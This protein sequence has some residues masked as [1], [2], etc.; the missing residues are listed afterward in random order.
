MLITD[1]ALLKA[2]N[3]IGSSV[4]LILDDNAN[5]E[6]G[7]Y[8]LVGEV[9]KAKSEIAQINT[10]VTLGTTI[11]VDTLTYAHPIGT[12]VYKIPYNQVKFYYS[13]T[14][15]GTK[16]LLS[17]G[18]V[19]IDA[20][21]EYTT[22]TDTVNSSGYLFFTLY[23][24][25]TTLETGYSAG[26]NYGSIQYGSRIKIRE[27]VTSKHNWSKELDDTT[28]NTLCDFAESE[29]FSIRRWRFREKTVTFDTVVNQQSYAK[30]SVGLSDMGQMIFCTYTNSGGLH[31][32]VVPVTI[33]EYEYINRNQIVSGNPRHIWEW[34]DSIYLTP[35]PSEI[36]TVSV[37]YYR[38][39][40]GFSDETSE[41]E[42]KLPQAI[43]YRILQDLW[44]M[45][46]INK[47]QYFERRYLQTISAM[48]LD[49]IKQ[50][51]KMQTLSDNRID[52][53]DTNNQIDNPH[54]T[55]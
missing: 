2:P 24:S 19:N 7:D 6:N 44:A 16:T 10:A 53:L 47:S 29:I 42:V 37:R 45:V 41:S 38:N 26:F 36:A 35:I 48:K 12:M 8:I 39:S 43:S 55:L 20:Q 21:N 15:T 11:V 46:D 33:K 13:A 32:P 31:Q 14:L 17:G 27:F 50:V 22:F 40:I 1:T 23:N 52:R 30:T 18:T 3:T 28:F 5:F 54:I 9:G 49:D 34:D 25:T 4:S 51:G